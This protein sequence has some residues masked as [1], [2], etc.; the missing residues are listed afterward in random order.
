MAVRRISDLPN[1]YEY[2]PDAKLPDCLIETSYAK[3]T[4]PRRYQSFYAKLQDV[5]QVLKQNL[6]RATKTEFGVVR[7]GDNINVVDTAGS[8]DQGLIS[9]PVAGTSTSGQFGVVKTGT[10]I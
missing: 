7:I 3:P 9:I 6:P 5:F 10:N 4:T 2:Y 1:L 8:P